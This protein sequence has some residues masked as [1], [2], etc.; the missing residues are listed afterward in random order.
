M[1][2][3][4]HIVCMECGN[5]VDCSGGQLPDG[6]CNPAAH[7]ETPPEGPC[8]FVMAKVWEPDA[9]PV[10][11]LFGAPRSTQGDSGGQG[12]GLFGRPA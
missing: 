2:Y 12:A 8:T 4:D 10:Q 7:G 11:Q 5:I 1:P 3:V 6:P 9:A